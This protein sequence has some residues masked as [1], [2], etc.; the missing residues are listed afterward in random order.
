MYN[1][2]NEFCDM[3]AAFT[4]SLKQSNSDMIKYNRLFLFLFLLFAFLFTS[5]QQPHTPLSQKEFEDSVACEKLFEWDDSIEYITDEFATNTPLSELETDRDSFQNMHFIKSNKEL[6][7]ILPYY[8]LPLES[9][10]NT[11]FAID[12]N[13]DSV[14]DYLYYGPSGGSPMM[15]KIFINMGS[16]YMEVF[17]DVQEIKEYALKDNRLVS[18]TLH[19][20]GC[21]ADPQHLSYYYT[22]HYK[23]NIPSFIRIKTIGNISFTQKPDSLTEDSMDF[24]IVNDSAHLRMVCYMLDETD[25]PPYHYSG[26]SIA[27]YGKCATGKLLGTRK[28]QGVDWVYVIMDVNPGKM[29]CYYPSFTGQPTHIKGWMLKSDTDLK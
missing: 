29:N 6:Q 15:T 26:T 7:Q 13:G 28:E 22:A 18:F 20:S 12:L 11:V 24:S 3:N 23:N 9:F 16:Y 5:G 4:H 8:S 19:N 21:C 2:A 1:E 17:S 25:C 27:K 14:K 10:V